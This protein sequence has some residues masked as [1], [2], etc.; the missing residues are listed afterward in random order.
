MSEADEKKPREMKVT[1]RRMFTPDGELR[2]E[3]RDVLSG[4]GAA[5]A[6]AEPPPA[7]EPPRRRE[8]PTGLAV[9]ALLTLGGFWFVGWVGNLLPDVSNPFREETIDRTGPAVLKAVRD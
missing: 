4:G 9:L 1:D 3:Y 5:T 8:F 2:E 6:T 7:P